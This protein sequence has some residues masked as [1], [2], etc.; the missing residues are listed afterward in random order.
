[1]ANDNINPATDMKKSG[2]VFFLGIIIFLVIPIEI[3][4]NNYLEFGSP[5]IPLLYALALLVVFILSNSLVLSFLKNNR[6]SDAYVIALFY[7]GVFILI[8][9]LISP[10]L[11][12]ILEKGNETPVEATHG[13][14]LEFA[15]LIGLL[16]LAIKSSAQFR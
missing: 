2:S 16:L 1:M 9:D 12:G 10:L 7:V 3:I 6:V 4:R 14:V 15:L 11:I 8:S 5:I 13:M